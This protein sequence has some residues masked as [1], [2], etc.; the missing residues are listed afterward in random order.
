MDTSS[1]VFEYHQAYTPTTLMPKTFVD[2]KL[3][4]PSMV[5]GY[6]VLVNI[7]VY[8]FDCP[9]SNYKT[10]KLK[11]GNINFYDESNKQYI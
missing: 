11:H 5:C 3:G 1:L 4:I 10:N 6:N 2:I 8:H 9:N 7:M